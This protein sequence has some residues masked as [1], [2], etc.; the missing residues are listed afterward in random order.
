[1][2]EQGFQ[3]FIPGAA[4]SLP[5]Q[6]LL[7]VDAFDSLCD[8]EGRIIRVWRKLDENLL[9]ALNSEPVYMEI[10]EVYVALQRGVVDG[11]ITGSGS[12]LTNSFDDV[13]KNYYGVQ[14][15]GGMGYYVVN[16]ELFEA[17]PDEYKKILTEEGESLIKA[18]RESCRADA[19]ECEKKLADRGVEIHEISPEE[20]GC[21]QQKGRPFWDE[22]VK[23]D[24]SCP[25]AY[26]AA[27]KA[28]GL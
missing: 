22:W 6:D 24:P 27:K 15:P 21:W 20:R 18:A 14:L 12:M 2:K 28:L 8:L 13:A 16:I 3:P 7:V 10:G 19:I 5:R 11:L 26:E 1:M 23:T 25:E 9:R 4:L 17:L